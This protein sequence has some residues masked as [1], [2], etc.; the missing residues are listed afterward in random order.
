MAR[1]YAF[2]ASEF[3]KDDE[4]K[5][6]IQRLNKLVYEEVTSPSTS[7]GQSDLQSLWEEGRK[8]SLDAFEKIYARIGVKYDKYYFESETAKRGREIVLANIENGIFEKDDGAVVFR[9]EKEGLHTRVF[10]TSED[11]ATY[12]AKDLALAVMKDEDLHYDKS[13]ILTGNE[14][15]EYFQVMLAALRKIEPSLAEKTKHFTFGHVRLKEGKMSSRT[16]EVVTSEWLLNEA[17]DRIGKAFPEMDN[18]TSEK[19]GVG[20][21]KYSMLKFGISSDIHF[22]FNES[23]S[24]EGNSGPYIQYAYVRTQSVL[25]R[26]K[27]KELSIKNEN[28]LEKEELELL[29]HL[30]YYPYYVEKAGVDFAPNLVCNYLFELSQKFN[31]FYQKHKIIGS[32]QEMFRLHLVQATGQVLKNGLNLLGIKTVER[33]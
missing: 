13:V 31:L 32:E 15:A 3:E 19:V 12:E 28:K 6:E 17:V 29:R 22:D 11:Y 26:I 5:K 27:N 10:L 8:V 16:G 2:G 23:I 30:S 18:N 4:V 9:G 1:A 25:D 14:Q 7:S 33:M 21:V 24:L 20:A